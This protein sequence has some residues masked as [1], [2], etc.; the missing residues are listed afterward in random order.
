MSAQSS[1]LHPLDE[2][3][4]SSG[5]GSGQNKVVRLVEGLTGSEDPAT[6]VK[7]Q[8]DWHRAAAAMFINGQPITSVAAAFD[9]SLE[10]IKLLYKE[11]HFQELVKEIGLENEGSFKTMLTGMGFDALM[12]L[13]II[14]V[15]GKTENAKASASKSLVE[16]LWGKPLPG[17]GLLARSTELDPEEEIKMLEEEQRLR[18]ERNE[19]SA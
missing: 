9:T 16:C 5:P 6:E 11:E 18:D 4:Q 2:A 10:H 1:G 3:Y 8:K 7:E 13:H 19:R 14:S 15:S 17:K 12:Q